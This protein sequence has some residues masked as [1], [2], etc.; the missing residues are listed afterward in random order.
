MVIKDKLQLRDREIVMTFGL[1]NELSAIVQDPTR[2]GAMDLDP[3]IRAKVLDSIFAERT[4]S[5]R[6]KEPAVDIEDLDIP[7]T[8]FE[9]ALDWAKEH[10]MGF[11]MRRMESTAK[12]ADQTKERM[13]KVESSLF[14]SDESRSET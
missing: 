10:V 14:G 4:K 12:V 8:E 6:R 2:I 5:G 1:L 13:K 9:K 7:Y 3:E 11:F